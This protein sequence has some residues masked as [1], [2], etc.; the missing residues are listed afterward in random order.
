MKRELFI[1]HLTS[2][3]SLFKIVSNNDGQ[4]ND[5]LIN[6]ELIEKFCESLRLAE[7]KNPWFT[8][9]NI[10]TSL[11]AWSAQLTEANLELWLKESSP[12]KNPKTVAIIMAGNIPFVG[13]HDLISVLASGH[14]ALLKLSSDDEVLMGLVVEAFY[15]VDA[16]Y[17]EL[18]AIVDGPM[19][20]FDAVIATGSDNTARYFDYYFGKYPHIIRKN[21]TSL[22]VITGKESRSTLESLGK[23]IFTYFGMGCR[24]VSHLLVP[25]GYDFGDFFEAMFG[26]GH[27]INH[28]KYVNNY[29]YHK[30]IFLLELIPF[31]DNNFLM[32]RENQELFSPLSVVHYSY[33]DSADDIT[34]Y[35]LDNSGKIQC[36]VGDNYLPFGKAQQPQL[37]DYADE[38]NTLEFLATLN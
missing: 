25:K 15:Q 27:L 21:R 26:H 23:D 3:G 30:A 9:E 20:N 36:V 17:R 8:Q 4:I 31:L 24:N 34:N 1:A 13:F 18:I 12:S 16:I 19:K 29:E 10:K 28:N 7:I 33:Y 11:L 22:A 38:L 35:I 37:W 6:A 2:I 32:I 14:K 5:H